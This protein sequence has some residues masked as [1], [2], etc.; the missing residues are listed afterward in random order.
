LAR[1]SSE[2]LIVLSFSSFSQ[3]DY[4]KAAKQYERAYQLVYDRHSFN[5]DKAKT[6]DKFTKLYIAQKRFVKAAET[7][8][9]AL[10]IRRKH[11]T[12]ALDIQKN[13]ADEL[14]LY[15]LPAVFLGERLKYTLDR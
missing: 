3:S 8:R 5:S 14:P 15:V 6:L 10:W 4:T 13:E 1:I 12:P 2:S 9:T 7:A 11:Y